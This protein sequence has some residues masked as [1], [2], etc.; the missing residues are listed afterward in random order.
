MGV[1][2][3]RKQ[4]EALVA[5]NR[6]ANP[7][8]DVKKIAESL[9][10]RV[11]LEDLGTDVSGLLV[12]KRNA[13]YVCVHKADAPHR[14]RFTIAH[15]VGHFVLGHQLESGEHVHVDKGHFISHRGPRAS[16]GIDP[17]EIEANQFA[18][19]LLMPASLLRKSVAR[20]GTQPV[21]DQH[22]A[23]L[24]KKFGVSEQAMTIRLTAMKLL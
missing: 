5:R 20:L 24:A 12:S 14:R 11:I 1:L 10:L 9:G 2:V 22:V 21:L 16:K 4:A 18:A 7:P 17:K 23:Q 8:V 15:E 19:S 13:A 3:A 6:I